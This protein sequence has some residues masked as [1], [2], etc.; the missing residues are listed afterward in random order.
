MQRRI[1]EAVW[2]RA[3]TVTAPGRARAEESLLLSPGVRFAQNRPSGL[4][5]VYGLALPLE[6]GPGDGE[7]SLL[8]YLSFEHP[9]LS[10][11]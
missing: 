11:R 10:G 8:L 9:F 3:E 7:R 4:Q 1:T 2:E 5:I 6:V